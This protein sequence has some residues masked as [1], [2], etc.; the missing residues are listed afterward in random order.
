MSEA[1]EKKERRMS[2]RQ[3]E[4][5][6]RKSFRAKVIAVSV[7]LAVMIVVVLVYNSN[8]FYS[9]TTAVQI[10]DTKYT[11]AEFNYYYYAVYENYAN[12][13]YQYQAYGF[14]YPQSGIPLDQQYYSSTEKVTWA[15]YFES[16]A[17]GEMRNLTMLYEEAVKAGRKLSQE[18]KDQIDAHI[19]ALEKSAKSGTSE[20]FDSLSGYLKFVYG[21]GMTEKLY[22]R[23]LERMM[24]ANG[25][26]TYLQESY[27]FTPEELKSYYE[28]HRD[29]YDQITYRSYFVKANIEEDDEETPDV[30]ETVSFTDAMAAAEK[31]AK[32]FQAAAVSE[33]AFVDYARTLDTLPPDKGASDTDTDTSDTDESE[34]EWEDKTKITA[35]VSNINSD[36]QEWLKDPS[37]KEGDVTV[38]SVGT[39][40]GTGNKGWYV[41]YYLSRDENDYASV[42]I[43]YMI[44]KPQSITKAEGQTDEEYQAQVDKAKQDAEAALKEV[45]ELYK[46]GEQTLDAFQKV[47]EDNQDKLTSGGSL[48]EMGTGDA[49]EV[50]VDWLFAA[51]RK[52][53]DTEIV[54]DESLGYVL[55]FY[56]GQGGVYADVLADA[57]KR[58]ETYNTWEEQTMASY[59]ADTKWSMRFSKHMLALGG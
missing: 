15:D 18:E 39:E 17:L 42:N 14:P 34:E 30:D 38:I 26:R 43:G 2:E 45:Y 25:Y 54:Y 16:Q 24:L 35:K 7:V 53:G 36:L 49:P 10:G 23:N 31:I 56:N 52:A 9:V 50:M 47:Y 33:E 4:E 58:S 41:L 13:Y 46:V 28:E 5:K 22:R 59:T 40:E 12:T 3:K 8:L 57:G 48:E 11:A 32:D 27:Q 6:E 19:E 21:K 1:N 37:R 44:S 29:S 20:N 55:M 51:E